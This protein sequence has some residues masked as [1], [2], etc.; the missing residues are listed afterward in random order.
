MNELHRSIHLRGWSFH[1][2][3]DETYKCRTLQNTPT[4][5]RQVRDKFQFSVTIVFMYCNFLLIIRL[6]NPFFPLSVS[7]STRWL[8]EEDQP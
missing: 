5:P 3:A 8:P 2:N 6:F 1:T 4:T 7:G